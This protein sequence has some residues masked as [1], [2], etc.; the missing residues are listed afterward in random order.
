MKLRYLHPRIG[1]IKK[2]YKESR[3]K[4]YVFEGKIL[5]LICILAAACNSQN[6]EAQENSSFRSFSGEAQGTTYSISYED[7]TATLFSKQAADSIL[8]AIDMSLSEWVDSSVISKF[9]DRD[10]IEISDPHFLNVFFRGREISKLT[11]GAFEPMIMP[12]V[13]AWG[14][15]PHG[16]IPKGEVNI[17]SLMTLV[18]TDIEITPLDSSAGDFNSAHFIFKKMKGQKLDVNGIAQGYSVDVIGDYLESKDI[19]NF[20]IEVGGEVLAHG[21][22]AHGE[23]WKIGIDKPVDPDQDRQLQAIAH[24]KDM[25]ICTSGSYRKFYEMNGKRFSHTINPQTGKPVE[26]N[27]I[28]TT[29]LAPNCTNGDTFATAF[30]VMGVEK[31]KE[32]V[33]DHP[34]LHLDV[35]LIYDGADGGW[36]SYM[37]PGMEKIT[38]VL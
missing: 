27:L 33:K 25:A 12:L 2:M 37:S 28:S 14:F 19:H 23:P 35:Y 36:E 30:M 22:N 1:K 29:V 17:D 32:F 11:D 8:D 31:T 3:T 34:E 24:V 13:H 9:N 21:Q 18:H 7:S 26:H 20:M 38:E 6:N 15:G 10:S 4:R 16:A 5:I